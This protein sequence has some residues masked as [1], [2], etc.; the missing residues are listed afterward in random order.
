MAELNL[1]DKN[2]KDEVLESKTP[3]LV[4]FW[5]SW[6]GPCKMQDPILD[7]LATEYEGEE[8]KIAKFNVEEGNGIPNQFQVM[9]IPTLIFFNGG[10]P[11]EVLSGVTEK[12]VLKK[13]IDK[14][15]N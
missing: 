5:A 8:I 11:V 6:C 9:S 12:D 14:L 4:D 3:V 13:K 10:K 15:L 2:F 7:E 1:T